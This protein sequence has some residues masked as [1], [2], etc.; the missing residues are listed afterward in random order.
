MILSRSHGHH[1]V[2]GSRHVRRGPG[3]AAPYRPRT[4][5]IL[6][7][8][9]GVLALLAPTAWHPLT[10]SA[11]GPLVLDAGHADVFDVAAQAG[12][13]ILR[14]RE[15][16]TGQHVVHRPESVLLTVK[17]KA[18]SDIPAGY[19]GA[20][21]GYLLP[22]SQDADLLWPGWN[23]LE[24]R[25]AGF[26]PVDIVV[27]GVSGPGN[28]HVFSQ[29]FDGSAE[30]LLTGGGFTLPGTI[31]VEEPAHVHANWVFSAAGTYTMTVKAVTT[32][33][34]ARLETAASTYTWQVGAKNE[35][36]PTP[37]SPPTPT[38]TSTPEP[39]ATPTSTPTTDSP[40]PTTPTPPPSDSA[41]TPGPVAPPPPPPPP[42]PPAQPAP[43]APPARPVARPATGAVAF[44]KG[45]T[46]LFYVTPQRGG[47]DMMLREDITGSGVLRRPE[48][49]RLLV[50]DNAVMTVPSGLPEAGRQAYVL[51]ITQNPQLL[52]PGWSTEPLRAAGMSAADI[53]VTVTGPGRV[54]LFSTGFGGK[55]SSV[56]T[57]G[58][59]QLPGRI[60]VPTP[61]HV[62]AN[63][64]FSAPG[65]YTL[66]A[67]ATAQG[68]QTRTATYTIAVGRTAVAA[69]V[70]TVSSVD[71]ASPAS[72]T[73]PSA[74]AAALAPA[75]APAGTALTAAAKTVAN[76]VC[77][78]H[79]NRPGMP[80]GA[81][82]E[83][84]FDV[85][86]QL[87]DGA[88]KAAVKDDRKAPPVWTDPAKVF[89]GLTDRAKHQAP[90]GLEF[91]A[92]EGRDIW[93]I[94][95]TQEA[96][97]PWV[98]ENSQH[99]S[100]VNGTSGPLTIRV[101]GVTGPGKVAHFLPGPLGSG[102]GTRLMDT[103][104]GPTSYTIPA[105]THQHGI[106][107]FD[108]PGEYRLNLTQEA[109]TTA[110]KK[111]NATT[112]LTV[113]AGGCTAEPAGDA[114]VPAVKDTPQDPAAMALTGQNVLQGS[115]LTNT[116]LI[117]LVVLNLVLLGMVV[118]G[119]RT[120][121]PG[122]D[123]PDTTV[124]AS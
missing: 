20:P 6:V 22:L 79:G 110:G 2:P 30:S 29:A 28:V 42:P 77:A 14:L 117:L 11:A 33:R 122:S 46:D 13:P 124:P 80:Q 40:T 70:P 119:R 61:A 32:H 92:A 17:Q 71:G 4:T 38:P 67:R 69:A 8:L 74:G 105:N 96:G 18:W 23:T 120:R 82:T 115:A 76:G 86:A 75:A 106:W 99:P 116:L 100:I 45:H 89:F 65:T 104:G 68:R 64:I 63:W 36:T 26:G 59:L 34:G 25:A 87:V 49:V 39:T 41:T 44:S 85:G 16:V 54:S 56:L 21:A 81:L 3:D 35:P 103:V 95:S 57:S 27:T 111:I 31:R 88:L 12:K 24:T 50:G 93:M 19:P 78:A 84:H 1:G 108:A 101:T 37:T 55:P 112:T 52:W 9:V 97:V 98:G 121:P 62:H 73:A 94:G 5:P 123:D 53:D 102:V 58:S 66:T 7:A 43:P 109:T 118:R 113:V 10:A 90:P 72:Y 91:I 60:Q 51:P 107:V 48:D 114:A 83:G 15:D 47:L